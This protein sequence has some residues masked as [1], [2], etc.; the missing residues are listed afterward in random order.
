MAEERRRHELEQ[1]LA[2]EL[3]MV[4]RA[5]SKASKRWWESYERELRK[6]KTGRKKISWIKWDT[7]CLPKKKGGLGV[8]DIRAVN[9]SLLSK[10]RWKL[11]DNSRA[12]WKDV[13]VSKYGANVIGR[14]DLG[15]DVKPW[16][17]FGRIM[18]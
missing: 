17:L 12:V 11:L 8:R 2:G 5:S 16:Y 14:L 9:I 18:Y 6:R 15:D 4:P 10:W 13:L 1:K 3:A 7:V